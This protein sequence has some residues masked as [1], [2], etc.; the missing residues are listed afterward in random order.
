[1]GDAGLAV[2]V[3]LDLAIAAVAWRARRR[4]LSPLSWIFGVTVALLVADV[5]TGA[6][7][8][9]A[10]ILGYSPQTASRWFGIGNTAFGVLAG[11]TLLLA[12]LHVAHAPRRREAL[13]TAAA[14][15]AVVIF[16]DGAPFL[17]ADVGGVVTLVPVGGLALMA[18]AGGRLTWRRVAIAGGATAGALAVVTAVDLLRPPESRTH[19]G[20]LA[21]ETLSS[22]DGSLF[23][24]LARRAEVTIDV[25]GQN[26]WTAVT[27]VIA[28]LVLVTLLRMPWARTRV[29]PGTPLR[30]G[31]LAALDRRPARH[32]G[33]RLGR[34]RGGHGDG[35]RR[36]GARPHRPD[37]GAVGAQR[38]PRTGGEAGPDHVAMKSI[39]AA[40]VVGYL[41]ARLTWL[42]TRPLFAL[43]ALARQNF[44][45]RSLPTAAGIVLPLAAVLVEGGR[46]VVASFGVGDGPARGVRLLVLAAALGFGLLGLIDDLAGGATDRGVPGPPRGPRPRAG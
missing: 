19:L 7:L 22:G 33:E 42:S 45:G 46:A 41:A 32:G 39:L 13:V 4:P 18:L 8:Q 44:R 28:V 43:P 2:L 16:V 12:G 21:S 6:R 34:D 26:F 20:R 36:A 35:V 38:P 14:L 3:A 10:G 15:L 17:G 40:V 31:L 37:R 25:I 1:M 23:A 30:V 5:A 27:P 24:T 9:L 29:P 11:A